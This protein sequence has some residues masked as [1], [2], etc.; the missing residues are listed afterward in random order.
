MK[1]CMEFRVEGRNQLEDHERNNIECGSGYG[2]SRKKMFMT[3][4][5]ITMLHSAISATYKD[6]MI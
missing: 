4:S 6:H 5:E 2:R 1:K 3:F